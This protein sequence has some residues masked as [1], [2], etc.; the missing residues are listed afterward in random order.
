MGRG[1]RRSVTREAARLGPAVLAM[2][3]IA[4]CSGGE[5]TPGGQEEVQPPSVPTHT[6]VTPA[7]YVTDLVF[8]GFGRSAPAGM[9]RFRHDVTTS[10]L[11]RRYRVWLRRGSGWD[12]ALAIRDSLPVP[13]AG[14]RVLP[15]RGLRILAGEGGEIAGLVLR[16]SAAAFTLRPGRALDEWTSPTGRRSR[17]L[18]AAWTSGADSATGLVFERREAR[19]YDVPPPRTLEESVLVTDSAGDGVLVLRDAGD[20]DPDHAAPRA[21]TWIGGS[22]A[23]WSTVEASR[24]PA[25]SGLPGWSIRIPDAR[26][27]AVLQSGPVA[28][29][30]AAVADSTTPDAGVRVYAVR[31]TLRL[32]GAS[33]PARG[34]AVRARGP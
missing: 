3:S 27:E 2:L 15:G 10:M 34:V 20:E 1:M 14:W 9:L 26:L 23:S 6:S 32:A 4:A 18:L 7:R 30:D 33:R 12:T 16:D 21:Y 8:V 31:G 13:R 22:E 17:L 19:S 11:V 28:T 5:P 25:A 29:D 24:E